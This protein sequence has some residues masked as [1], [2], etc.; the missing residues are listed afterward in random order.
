[1]SKLKILSMKLPDEENLTPER[2]REIEAAIEA[3]LEKVRPQ[4]D[5]VL[6]AAT[7]RGIERAANLD[8]ITDPALRRSA[9]EK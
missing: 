1:M 9:A 8:S 2:R 3:A 5:A 7:Q 4:M 6:E